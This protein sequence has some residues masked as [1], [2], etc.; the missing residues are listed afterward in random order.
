MIIQTKDDI[1]SILIAMHD[2]NKATENAHVRTNLVHIL[3]CMQKVGTL[4]LIN[5]KALLT[6]EELEIAVN[7]AKET[8]ENRPWYIILRVKFLEYIHS[9]RFIIYFVLFNHLSISIL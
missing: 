5:F 3:H 4:P 1:T 6:S 2:I 9:V 7:H 8:K